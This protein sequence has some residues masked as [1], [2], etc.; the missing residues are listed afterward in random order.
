MNW[1]QRLFKRSKMESQLD[2]ELSFHIAQHT[3]DLMAQGYSRDEARR[4]A[5]I[6]FG[7]AEKAKEECREARGTRWLEDFLH[8][9][10]YAIRCLVQKPGFAT[11]ALLTL[12][13]GTGA[14][15]VMFSLLDGVLLKPLPY[16][17]PDR[18]LQLQE[19]TD[20]STRL[21]DLWAFAYPN[22]LDCKREVQA[23]ETIAFRYDGGT[24]ST[25]QRA[26]YVDGLEIS[27]DTF[28]VLGV[29]L[30]RGRAF[31][32]EEDRQGAARVAIISYSLWQ[33]LYGG[34]ETIVGSRTNFD[35]Q[36]YTIIGVAPPGFHVD[37][38]PQ[39]EG[40]AD[41]FLPLGQDTSP[42]LLRRDRHSAFKSD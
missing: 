33:R 41:I 6:A 26:E 25:A 39:L 23:L 30:V 38:G 2:K 9:V 29:P 7:G 37:G 35:Q 18:L 8:D 27:V 5:L 14:T 34:D 24:V 12:A 20:W 15:T 10:R 31:A 40:G 36:T 32:L 16:A 4:Q 17:H 19:K 3:E 13:L 11:V 22:Y 28:A 1:V 42:S 21:G